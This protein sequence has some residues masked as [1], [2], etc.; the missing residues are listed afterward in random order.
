MFYLRC[1]N[2]FAAIFGNPSISLRVTKTD[3]PTYFFSNLEFSKKNKK[4]L[5]IKQK[6]GESKNGARKQL[7]FKQNINNNK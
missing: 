5:E 2:D 6:P 4:N 1:K 7:S 3:L